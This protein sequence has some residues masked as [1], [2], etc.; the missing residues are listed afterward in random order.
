MQDAA[1]SRR[2]GGGSRRPEVAAV[3]WA[4]LVPLFLLLHPYRGLV[5]DARIYIGRGLADRDPAGVGQDMM[6]AH[7]AQTSFSLMRGLV[8]AALHVASPGE[9]SMALA[10]LGGLAWLLGAA[11]LMRAL[12]SGRTAWAAMVCVIALPATYG[13]YGVFSYIEAVATPRMF[14][15]AAVLGALAASTRGK[16]LPCVVLLGLAAAFHPL[17]ALPGVAIVAVSLIGEDRRWLVPVAAAGGAVLAA[18]VLG[19]SPADRLLRP[20]D[21]TWLAILR[22]RSTY[23]F[24]SQWPTASFGPILCQAA[25]VLAAAAL[26]AGRRRVLLLS[27]LGVAA[28]GLAG[29]WAFGDLRASTLVAQVQLWRWL[30]PLAV[31]G[32]ASLALVAVALWRRGAVARLALATIVCMNLMSALLPGAALLA[33][34]ALALVAATLRQVAIARAPF[35]ALCMA[36]AALVLW[37]SDFAG[38]TLVLVSVLRSAAAE[39]GAVDWPM[40]AAIG[41]PSVP[42]AAGAIALALPSAPPRGWSAPLGSALALVCIGAAA[43]WLWDGRS[44]ERRL[45]DDPAG[46]PALRAMVGSAPGDVLWIDDDSEG[47]FLLG[48][49]AFLNEAQAGPILFSRDLAVEWADRAALLLDLGLVRPENVHPWLST[50]RSAR[51]LVLTVDG[52]ARFCADPRRPAAIVAPGDQRGAA[53]PGAQAGLWR[54]A[55]PLTRPVPDDAGIHW[56]SIALLTVIRCGGDPARADL[57]SVGSVRIY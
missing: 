23:L 45:V 14:A 43:A 54:P 34:V 40:V 53:P 28:C 35:Y 33:A 21:P 38:S 56:R 47:W 16:R 15:E 11:A 49:P 29:S 42:L 55:T 22:G 13:A 57:T 5:Q 44:A 6:F 30:W 27:I 25:T 4:A 20:V 50:H 31:V 52:V 2:V 26:A 12:S 37:L 36:V 7:D 1:R 18:A 19:I 46:D 24:P 3:W 48:R 17:M 9:A 32:Q 41:L 8:D 39:G 51:D 10:F